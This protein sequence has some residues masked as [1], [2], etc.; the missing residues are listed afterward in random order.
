MCRI[1]PYF[2]DGRI[3]IFNCLNEDLPPWEDSVAIVTDPPY[4][5]SLKTNFK[6]SGRSNKCNS[7]DFPPVYA[8]DAPFNPAPFLGNRELIM[9]GANYYASRL[10]DCGKWLIWDKRVDMPSVDQADAEM[11]WTYNLKGTVPRVFRHKWMGMI[12]DS[13]HGEKRHH[14]TQKP[15]ALMKWC[16]GFIT[17]S[18]I[19]DPF[20]GAGS[21]LVAAKS[22]GFKAV[23]VEINERYCEVAAG[24]LSQGV[25]DFR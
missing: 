5:V 12:K 21:T 1:E 23:G 9:W 24:R 22:L 18:T 16:L 6:S 14:P 4:G 8:D 15:I 20:M 19:C 10:P 11:A 2:T 7:Q 17:S 25:L 13:E 3:T